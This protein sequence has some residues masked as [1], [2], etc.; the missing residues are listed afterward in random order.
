MHDLFYKAKSSWL[1]RRRHEK[2]TPSTRSSAPNRVI[3]SISEGLVSRQ[4]Y[5][6]RPAPPSDD[7]WIQAE[8]KMRHNSELDTIMTASIEILQSD[9]D[10]KFQP[11]DSS[12]HERLSDFL[13]TRANLV[14]EKKWMIH[15]GTHTI[16]VR[17]QL[18][19]A[20]QNILAVKDIVTTAANASLPASLACAGIMACFTVSTG[21][22]LFLATNGL[23][24]ND[25]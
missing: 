11:V 24:S 17:D 10:L 18:T 4:E 15:L 14:E 1:R 19:K 22:V 6:H 25:V 8:Q 16:I 2:R 9:Y 3:N 13:K 12:L 21:L 5:L 7:L 20:F 23:L